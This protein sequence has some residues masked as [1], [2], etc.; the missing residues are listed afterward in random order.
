MDSPQPIPPFPLTRIVV[1]GSQPRYYRCPPDWTCDLL[2]DDFDLWFVFRGRGR[3]SINGQEHVVHGPQIF[4]FQPGERVLGTHEPDEPLE[5]IAFHFSASAKERSAARALALRMCGIRPRDP[6][7]L[8][9]QCSWLVYAGLDMDAAGVLHVAT[10]GLA[11]LMQLWR[12]IHAPPVLPA[13]WRVEALIQK[14]CRRPM[15]RWDTRRM[16][17]E[18]GISASHVAKR[19]RAITGF[20]PRHFVIRRRIQHAETLMA[21]TRL[22]LAQ[23][24]DAAGYR[25]VFFF[26]RQFRQIKGVSPAFF[27]KTQIR[28]ISSA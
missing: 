26:S 10:I 19:F 18:T 16:A 13:D 17:K 11:I 14:I 23:I 25:D 4:V 8:R 5:V 15:E 20:A 9:E 28:R 22:S 21:D 7:Q 12:E 1:A 6:A 3:L 2:L 24:A 27:R